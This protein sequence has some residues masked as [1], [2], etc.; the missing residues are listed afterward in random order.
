MDSTFDPVGDEPVRGSGE[1]VVLDL[2]PRKCKT[3][4]IPFPEM[5]VEP[6][7]VSHPVYV[8]LLSA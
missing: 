7:A 6:W 4:K 5:I 8:E 1:P 3:N 2:P